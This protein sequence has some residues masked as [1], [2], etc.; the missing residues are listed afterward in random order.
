MAVGGTQYLIK[1]NTFYEVM[2]DYCFF[3]NDDA[4]AKVAAQILRVGKRADDTLLRQ[5]ENLQF[6]TPHELHEI[7]V[8]KLSFF[9][10]TL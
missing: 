1:K 2:L 7:H 8:E 4:A 9:I 5:N 10:E 3:D 6:R